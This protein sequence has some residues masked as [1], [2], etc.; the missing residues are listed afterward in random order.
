MRLQ[1]DTGNRCDVQRFHMY[2]FSSVFWL[3][4]LV[5]LNPKPL[6]PKPVMFEVERLAAGK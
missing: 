1:T 3:I 4:T 6:T 5:A 2:F